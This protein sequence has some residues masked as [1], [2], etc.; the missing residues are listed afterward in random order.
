MRRTRGRNG[1]EVV[2]NP[3]RRVSWSKRRGNRKKKRKRIS[4]NNR[5]R[6]TTKLRAEK[7]E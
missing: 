7:T 5:G 3:E 4:D 6:G 2:K 1:K